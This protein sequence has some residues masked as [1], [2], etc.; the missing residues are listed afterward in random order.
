MVDFKIGKARASGKLRM[1][2]KRIYTQEIKINGHATYNDVKRAVEKIRNKLRQDKP[3]AQ[4]QVVLQYDS[5]TKPI[6]APFF[7]VTG[8]I[9]MHAP[10]DYNDDDEPITM[11]WINYV[12]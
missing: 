2:G 5:Q 9:K 3:N 11:L 10:Y 6:A 4:M 1:N 7:A 8:D 12:L